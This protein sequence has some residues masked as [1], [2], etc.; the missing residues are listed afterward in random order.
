MR[1]NI[2][3]RAGRWSAA[4]WKTATF[5]W[6]AFV[7]LAVVLGGAVGT[8]TLGEGDSPGESGRMEKILEEGFERPAEESVL[9]QSDSVTVEDPSFADAV[10]DVV[11]ALDGSLRVSSPAGGPTTVRAEL[12]CG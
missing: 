1:L 9:V 2:A 7:V 4:H 3:A 8:K 11:D 5:G 12:P 10:D 6:I